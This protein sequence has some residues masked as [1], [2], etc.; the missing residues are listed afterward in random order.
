MILNQEYL[1][2]MVCQH[3][4]FVR[5]IDDRKDSQFYSYMFS[6]ATEY[7]EESKPILVH[8]VKLNSQKDH[9]VF[10]PEYLYLLTISDADGSRMRTVAAKKMSCDHYEHLGLDIVVI[11][12]LETW[13][14][15]GRDA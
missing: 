8:N 12:D 10:G 5:S 1:E 15:E 4:I 14:R 13:L 11:V 3:C 7:S 6:S 9:N 2:G